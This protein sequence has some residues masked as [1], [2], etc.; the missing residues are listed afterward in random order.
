MLLKNLTL[1]TF[2]SPNC[3]ISILISLLFKLQVDLRLSFFII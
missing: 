1:T 3:L 2:V